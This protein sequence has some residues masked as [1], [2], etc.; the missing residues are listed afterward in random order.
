[1]SADFTYVDGYDAPAVSQHVNAR[2]T[3]QPKLF[4]LFRSKKTST[5]AEPT[6]MT[7]TI[8]AGAY[9]GPRGST[10][11]ARRQP[12]VVNPPH[13]QQGVPYQHQPGLPTLLV[14]APSRQDTADFNPDAELVR[15]GGGGGMNPGQPM[16][17]Q[18]MN[19]VDHSR[20]VYGRGAGPALVSNHG[21]SQ[22]W[23][24]SSRQ[25]PS[26][27]DAFH[28]TQSYPTA[29]AAAQLYGGP[30]QQR[31]GSPRTRRSPRLGEQ[32][33]SFD[34]HWT[35]ADYDETPGP[36]PLDN[37]SWERRKSLPSI[38]KLPATTPPTLATQTS[39]RRANQ[40][41]RNTAASAASLQ[42]RTPQVETYVIENGVRKRVR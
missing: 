18:T 32:Q 33:R 24:T 25:Q 1:M 39:Q 2:P 14:T 6:H 38:V 9:S 7:T 15:G 29:A 36:S 13:L 4:S 37:V 30:I 34:D 41:A 17:W 28:Q 22:N 40:T 12:D 5:A 20:Q 26:N 42:Q 23:T 11:S 10:T 27:F 3:S 35:T 21:S 16:T 8:T 31:E 19:A